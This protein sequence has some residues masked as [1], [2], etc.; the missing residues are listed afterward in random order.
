MESDF[1][2]ILT[3]EGAFKALKLPGVN[4]DILIHDLGKQN[5]HLEEN[6]LYRSDFFCM[7]LVKVD[8]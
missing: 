5:Y 3:L 6:L 8:S 7:I 1:V 2:S 4:R